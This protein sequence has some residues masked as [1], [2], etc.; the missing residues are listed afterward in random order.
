MSNKIQTLF[1]IGKTDHYRR[2]R[3]FQLDTAFR[4]GSDEQIE[5]RWPDEMR[6]RAALNDWSNEGPASLV[7][8]ASQLRDYSRIMKAGATSISHERFEDICVPVVDR[9]LKA[10]WGTAGDLDPAPLTVA[11]AAPKRVSAFITISDQ[12]RVQNPI[13]AGSF[14]E[15]QLLSSV[16]AALDDAILNGTGVGEEPLGILA[17]PDVLSYERASAGVSL[18]SDTLAMEKAISDAFGEDDAGQYRWLVASDS[19]QAARQTEGVTGVSALWE[20][21]RILDYSV[22]VMPTAPN[23]TMVLA[24][25]PSLVVYDWQRLTIENVFDVAQAKQGLRTMLVHGYFNVGVL[26]PAAVCVAVDPA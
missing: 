23:G 4:T 2:E 19:R 22:E 24:Q 10:S 9:S 25:M 12:L 16:G 5:L 13:L 21:R 17:D 1:K 8:F 14:I 3:L 18:L 7:T 6:E 11:D 20:N 26:N 15:A